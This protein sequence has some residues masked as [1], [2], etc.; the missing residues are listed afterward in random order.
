VS[1]RA[2]LFLENSGNSSA[3]D[4]HW[5]VGWEMNPSP[6]PNL[7]EVEDFMIRDRGDGL[8]A[9][10]GKMLIYDEPNFPRARIIETMRGAGFFIQGTARYKD[11]FGAPRTNRFCVVLYN[12]PWES[13]SRSDEGL[14]RLIDRVDFTAALCR[15]NNCA[16][17]TCEKQ[18]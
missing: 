9:P 14:D 12:G 17:K 15:R 3:L 5:S 11:I 7:Q 13:D 2:N 4:L 1:W 18:K 8:I 10:K 16:D 6:N